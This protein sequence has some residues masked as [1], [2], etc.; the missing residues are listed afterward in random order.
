MTYNPNWCYKRGAY[1]WEPF[2]LFTICLLFGPLFVTIMSIIV[3]SE[4]P[5]YWRPVIFIGAITTVVLAKLLIPLIFLNTSRQ[6]FLSN[7]LPDSELVTTIDS[8][9][10]KNEIKF[11]K[12]GKGKHIFEWPLTFY[13][14]IF[15][16]K[17]NDITIYVKSQT[18][19]DSWISIGKYSKENK[20]YITQITNLLDKAI[21]EKEEHQFENAFIEQLIDKDECTRFNA[22]KILGM[23]ESG[24][25][26]PFLLEALKIEEN[27]NI[28]SRII[29]SL[30]EIKDATA[31]LPLKN[32]LNTPSAKGN[33]NDNNFSFENLI[34][35]TI[36]QIEGEK[37]EKI[38][39]REP[40]NYND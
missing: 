5:D 27:D 21:H 16:L 10:V 15:D 40:Y 24:K 31:I 19:K 17:I 22:A 29:V 1:K 4:N 36:S 9:L 23:M 30:G 28:I 33:S 20:E 38:K 14:E 3:Y 8:V 34:Q 7:Q 26:V 13:T 39:I 2:P 6:V 35:R 12:R 32:Y 37:V 18:G 11:D 25:A